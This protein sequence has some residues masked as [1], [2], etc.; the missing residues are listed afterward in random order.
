VLSSLDDH[1]RLGLAISEPSA[2]R[3]IA[4]TVAV[5]PAAAN[6]SESGDS[7][8]ETATCW[9]EVE[10]FADAEPEVAVMVA[11]P[12]ATAVTRPAIETV[13]T[14]A[15][16]VAHVTLAPLIVAPFWSL[17][18][19]ESWEVSPSEAKLRLVDDN[20][21]EVATGVGGVGG[22]GG[23]VGVVPPSPHARSKRTA[24]SRM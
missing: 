3:T 24:E 13:A 4:V 2:S 7:V 16:E 10:A 14:D 19:A 1:I 18:V 8:I 12:F 9:M 5:S 22:V 15:E 11:V 23:L 6:T 21:I 17:T 20:V